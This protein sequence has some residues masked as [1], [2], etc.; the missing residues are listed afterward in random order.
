VPGTDPRADPGAP[1]PLR[2]HLREHPLRLVAQSDMPQPQQAIWDWGVS[3][4]R[5]R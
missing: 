5:H 2:V 3:S 1:G 4:E